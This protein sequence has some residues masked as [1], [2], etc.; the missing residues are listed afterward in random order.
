MSVL[1][2]GSILMWNLKSI[3]CVLLRIL[4]PPFHRD[5]QK[6]QRDR[7]PS[8]HR[9][10]L[11]PILL[12]ERLPATIWYVRSKVINESLSIHIGDMRPWTAA[13]SNVLPTISRSKLSQNHWDDRNKA[14]V[15]N[16]PS[17]PSL[18]S[19]LALWQLH[20]W[21]CCFPLQNF[22]ESGGKAFLV[23]LTITPSRERQLPFRAR[24][25]GKKRSVSTFSVTGVL[26]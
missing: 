12:C 17:S 25:H 14:N 3:L 26:R 20:I 5:H 21:I 7:F 24:A 6:L 9:Y 19:N 2:M 8:V 22:P 16:C 18:F 10:Q 13:F 11:C 15:K 1:L 4:Q 23:A